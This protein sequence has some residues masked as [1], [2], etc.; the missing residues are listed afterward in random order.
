MEIRCA[1]EARSS[2]C[3]SSGAAAETTTAAA[4]D[5]RSVRVSPLSSNPR[6]A[7][8]PPDS[9]LSSDEASATSRLC[10][11]T[12]AAGCAERAAAASS[13]TIDAILLVGLASLW[14]GCFFHSLL[15]PFRAGDVNPDGPVARATRRGD[16]PH[17]HLQHR[18]RGLAVVR[19]SCRART[20]RFSASWAVTSPPPRPSIAGVTT[21]LRQR[22][23][24][25]SCTT[26]LAVPYTST[27]PAQA[28]RDGTTR[29]PLRG[30]RG[31]LTRLAASF[32][33]T[34]LRERRRG[35]GRA[36]W[37]PRRPRHRR[38]A[39]LTLLQ[40]S[41]RRPGVRQAR[42]ALR[43]RRAQSGVLSA[44]PRHPRTS[45]SIR[46]TRAKPMAAA[47]SRRRA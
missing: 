35:I 11:A 21:P 4:G 34:K 36:K 7:D 38:Q 14:A 46:M 20:K 32:T 18:D 17:V 6:H 2:T 27:T 47:R 16:R 8:G 10:R 29:A 31:Q 44:R 13:S 45:E 39:R 42:L 24:G 26:R 22:M 30:G 15:S 5:A 12:R 40:P 1:D 19:W 43:P 23:H 33:T 25:K 9:G 28:S 41:H 37:V 3:C